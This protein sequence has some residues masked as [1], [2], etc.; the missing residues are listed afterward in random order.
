MALTCDEKSSTHAVFRPRAAHNLRTD[1][2]AVRFQFPVAKTR[3]GYADSRRI[4]RLSPNRENYRTH[5]F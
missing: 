1:R 3:V 5:L 2:Q 4:H